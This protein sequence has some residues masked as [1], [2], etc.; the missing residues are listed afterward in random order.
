[1]CGVIC[2]SLSAAFSP[3]QPHHHNHHYTTDGFHCSVGNPELAAKYG[4]IKQD[5]QIAPPPKAGGSPGAPP[6]DG[7]TASGGPR[8]APNP[9]Q[10]SAFAAYGGRPPPRYV[11]YNVNNNTSAPFIPSGMMNPPS[12]SNPGSAA[13]SP[14]PPY[15]GGGVPP[16]QQP[17]PGGYAPSPPP[18]QTQQQQQQPFTPPPPPLPPSAVPPRGGSVSPPRHSPVPPPPPLPAHLPQAPQR[19]A[20]TPP[21]PPPSLPAAAPKPPSIPTLPAPNAVSI[22][23]PDNGEDAIE[24]DGK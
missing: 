4:H 13:A 15:A 12:L 8:A 2:F 5:I 7:A 3:T 11:T 21:P 6:G 17:G 20:F 19:P 14:I 18:P 10:Y 9:T 1:M 22:F 24:L 23:Q 16:H